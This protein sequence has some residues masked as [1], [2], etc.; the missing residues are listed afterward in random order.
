[1]LFQL[2]TAAEFYAVLDRL[3]Q[4][5]D[6]QTIPH[7]VGYYL[8]RTCHGST[9]SKVVHSWVLARSNRRKAWDYWLEALESDVADVQGGTTGE[10]IRLGAMAGTVDLLQRAFTGLETRGDALGLDPYLPDALTGMRFRLRYRGHP[11][12]E[13]T[14]THDRLTVGSSAQRA[15]VL[16][17]RRATTSTDSTPAAAWTCRCTAAVRT[18]PE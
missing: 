14:I 1:M 17:L 2:L 4:G 7:T 13:V 11:E 12:G 16:V 10:G 5:H 9:L 6:R 8:D 18:T 15:A 3:G